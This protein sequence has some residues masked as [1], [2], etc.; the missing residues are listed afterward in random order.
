MFSKQPPP[1]IRPRPSVLCLL[2]FGIILTRAFHLP[3]AKAPTDNEQHHLFLQGD[4]K[5]RDQA[6]CCAGT[7]TASRRIVGMQKQQKAKCDAEHSPIVGGYHASLVG[8]KVPHVCCSPGKSPFP[9][10][11]AIG[12]A[13]S[14]TN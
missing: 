4:P 9:G 8:Y 10:F 12:K 2:L 5:F 11:I 1:Q 7:T 13:T 6:A 3:K 14:K